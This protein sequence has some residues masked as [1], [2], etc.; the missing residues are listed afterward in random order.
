[1]GVD[2][3]EVGVIMSEKP[4]TYSEA[5]ASREKMTETLFDHFDVPRFYVATDGRLALFGTANVTGE[6][7]GMV[8][9]IGFSTTH[10]VPIYETYDLPHAVLRTGKR[11]YSFNCI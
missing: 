8:V 4:L 6:T 10:I 1:M 5:K 2:S 3:S 9:D 11:P 7:T